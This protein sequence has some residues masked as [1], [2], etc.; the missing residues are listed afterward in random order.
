MHIATIYPHGKGW[1]AQIR[2]L[3]H[4]PLSK[5]FPLKGQAYAWAEKI[6]RDLVSG[7]F[8][9]E[10]HTLGEAF[11][12]YAEEVS[13]HKRGGRWEIYR[14]QAEPLRLARMASKPVNSIS[15]ADLSQ[16]RDARLLAVSGA[17]V[18]RE[19]NLIE[20]VFEIARKEWK[21]IQANP[22]K[23]VAKPKNPRSRRRRVTEA[24]IKAVCGKLTGPSG[25]EVAAG[26]LLGIETGMRA[27]EL[28]SLTRDQIDIGER[29][30]R[31]LKTKNG[32]ERAVAL[33]SR[34]VEII[35]GLLADKRESLF[36]PTN[37]VRDTL[38]RKARKAAGIANLHFHDSRTEA[39]FRLSKKLDVLELAR[40]IGHRD[41]KSLLYYYEAD[42]AELAKKLD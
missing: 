7:I 20:S 2:R 42:A 24:E 30:A 22:I 6:E 14:L 13:P 28:W 25:K 33:S 4:P 16:W 5:T 19:M 18:R 39:I 29:V 31:L 9:P 27:G 10:K 36:P 26:F 37:A 34:A 23:D 38:F 17:S 40:Q 35:E 3:G 41:L 21:W 8:N 15:A 32:D 12:K 11:T 1:R